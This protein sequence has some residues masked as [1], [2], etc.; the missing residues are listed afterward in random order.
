MYSI[1]ASVD[2]RLCR[3][4]AVTQDT[5]D[6]PRGGEKK[7]HTVLSRVITEL[8]TGLHTEKHNRC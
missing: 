4:R 6:G 7:K 1:D 5:E 8:C 3:I 2:I